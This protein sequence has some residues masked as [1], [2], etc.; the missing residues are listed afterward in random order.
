MSI[1]LL[2]ALAIVVGPAYVLAKLKWRRAG[3]VLL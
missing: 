1:R 2:L 3:S